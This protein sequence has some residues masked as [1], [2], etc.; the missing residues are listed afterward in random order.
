MARGIAPG[1]GNGQW[2]ITNRLPW[3]GNWIASGNACHENG[4]GNRY[5]ECYSWEW[6]GASV[7]GIDTR[8]G[9]SQERHGQCYTREWYPEIGAG[10][11]HRECYP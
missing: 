7:L 3:N 9:N 2:W 1:N 6:H 5:R 8:E 10:H 11:R 4:T